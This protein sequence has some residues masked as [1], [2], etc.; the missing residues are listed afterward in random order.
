MSEGRLG[1]E[2]VRSSRKGGRTCVDSRC[3]GKQV[4]CI[5]RVFER[6][7]RACMHAGFDEDPRNA[8]IQVG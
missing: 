5:F 4:Q 7:Y 6:I 3:E 8:Y 1:L 2:I